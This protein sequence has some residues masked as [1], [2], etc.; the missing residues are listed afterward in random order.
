MNPSNPQPPENE[1]PIISSYTDEQAVEDGELIDLTPLNV[2]VS[3]REDRGDVIP[4][5][6]L[7]RMTRGLYFDVF[8]GQD[9]SP[10]LANVIKAWLNA[11]LEAAVYLR[12]IWQ[13]PATENTPSL[14]F[15]PNEV[16]GWTVMRPEDY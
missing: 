2:S 15:M 10:E 1:W 8:P 11:K 16:G 3:P 4:R 9:E 13:V 6:P 12:D 14:W 5:C 7:N